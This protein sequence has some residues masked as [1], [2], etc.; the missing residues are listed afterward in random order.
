M[1]NGVRL[2]DVADLAGVSIGTASQALNNRPNVAPETR[3][4]VIDAA[5]TLGYPTKPSLEP[6]TAGI[7]VVG[8]LTKH[9]FGYPPAINAFYSH[10]QAGVESECRRQHLSLMYSNIEVDS[11]NRP[12]SWPA[13]LTEERIDGLL[14]AGAFIENVAWHFKRRLDIP[15]VLIDAYATNLL[16]DSVL[17]DNDRGTRS[18]IEYLMRLGHRRI[19][20]IGT[21][22]ASPPSLLERRQSFCSVLE[23]HG[24]DPS[25]VVD[26]EL[27]QAAG[28]DSLK[29]LL[30][31][32]PEVTAVFAA[33]DLVAIG[34]LSA[35]RDMGVQV[36]EQLSI[37]GF[38]DIDLAA[39]VTPA[40]TT[41]HVHK[42]WMGTLAV[43]QLL[44]RAAE[45]LQPKVSITLATQLVER[46]SVSVARERDPVTRSPV[47]TTSRVKGG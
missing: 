40:L 45:P 41:I 26:S 31:H 11:S 18:A 21:N 34:A 10:V 42:T 43:R 4:R 14:L 20:L 2:Q 13:M 47:D 12:V 16:Y 39:V 24:L 27:S 5:K 3:V 37:I 44:Y 30:E 1:P 46:A 32:T 17:I 15:I 25:Y 7:E 22:S 9:D 29:H 19:G 23:A 6:V 35:A 33:A 28:Y 8:L 38:D 36:P